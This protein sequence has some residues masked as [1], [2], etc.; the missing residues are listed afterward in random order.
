MIK[1]EDYNSHSGFQAESHKSVTSK[2]KNIRKYFTS[3]GSMLEGSR[4]MGR[5]VLLNPPGWR[6]GSGQKEENQPVE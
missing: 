6:L 1:P 2:F 4:W 3:L 5:S